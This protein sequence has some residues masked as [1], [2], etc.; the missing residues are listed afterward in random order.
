MIWKV[1][2]LKKE[3]VEIYDKGEKYI[4]AKCYAVD[5]NMPT[6]KLNIEEFSKNIERKN[7]YNTFCV[8]VRTDEGYIVDER[9]NKKNGTF[10]EA[11]EDFFT[12]IAKLQNNRKYYP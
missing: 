3:I 5:L 7:I 2:I 4:I 1:I 12:H 6:R 11:F 8:L 9:C 10:E